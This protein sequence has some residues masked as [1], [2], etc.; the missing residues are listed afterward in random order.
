V[1]RGLELEL[2]QKQKKAQRRDIAKAL[3]RERQ[4]A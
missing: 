3:R 4:R 1:Q 2:R